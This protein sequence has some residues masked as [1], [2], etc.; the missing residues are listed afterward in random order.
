MILDN[1][2]KFSEAQAITVTAASPNQLDMG[3][4]GTTA[5]FP[6]V[7][8]QHLGR[9]ACVPLLI[10]VVEDFAT[11]TS[12]TVQLRQSASS[13][14]ASP[15]VLLEQTIPVAK[16]KAGFKVNIDVLPAEVTQRY[17]D[18][19]YI[20]TGTTATAGKI[21]AMIVGAVDDGYGTAPH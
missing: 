21:S 9:G 15:T 4:M 19:N 12:L 3:Q 10:Q 17:L 18:V 1:S 6:V 2:L 13:N 7:L 11:L 20:V 5:Y 8:R 14:M 16:L